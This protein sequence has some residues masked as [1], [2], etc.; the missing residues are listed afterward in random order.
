M[1]KDEKIKQFIDTF[2]EVWDA[3]EWHANSEGYTGINKYI[4][5]IVGQIIDYFEHAE[6]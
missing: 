5:G 1:N 4:R 6:N 2:P 3:L